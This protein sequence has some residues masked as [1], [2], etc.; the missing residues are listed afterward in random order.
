MM[1]KITRRGVLRGM[2]SGAV[3]TV[4]LPLLDIFLNDNGTALAAG[5]GFPTRFGM[6]F[7]GNGV[8]PER[9]VPTGEGLH[10]Q[11][12]EQM[13]GLESVKQHITVVSGTELKVPN[14]IPH[15]S[16]ACGILSG[17]TLIVDG[18][19]QTFAG[20]TI[21][22]IIAEKIGLDTRFRSIEYGAEA[23]R[24]LSYNGPDNQNPPESSPHALF[25]RIFGVGFR[26]PGEDGAVD[27]SILLR[28]S[29]LDSV[30]EDSRALQSRVG[31]VDRTRLEQHFE[32]IR[33][34]EIRLQRL[35]EDPPNLAACVRPG[36]PL[37]E[38][39]PIDG[40]PQI[41][42]KNRA[43]CDLVAIA[44]A[45]DQ[46]RVFSN[47]VTAPVNNLLF[48]GASAGHH[49]LTHDEPGDQ[50]EVNAIVKQLVAEFGYMVESLASVTEG[51]ATLL[52][53]C[54]VLCTTDVSYGRTHSLTEFPLVYAGSANGAL[55]TGLH[56]RSQTS[57]NS[58][59]VILTLARALGVPLTTFGSGDGA[60]TDSIGALEV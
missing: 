10:W 9:W 56:Y 14:L 59:R 45:C 47:F 18:D 39:P 1:R 42:A 7:W 15:T 33:E 41:Q 17:T 51:D 27:P 31:A 3:V 32:G 19:N 52:D 23:G 53:H 22:Q 8:H 4:G 21:D 40:R 29:V 46:T 44:L 36:E 28:R 25:E 11:L 12:S 5:E 24:G 6:Y 20:P 34:L 2:L 43:L 54:V 60:A 58:A 26:A 57:E 50:P 49:Q 37:P 35:Q 30:M 48:P 55:K 38:Y 16:G 13:S